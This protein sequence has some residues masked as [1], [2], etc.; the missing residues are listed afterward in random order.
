MARNNKSVTVFQTDYDFRSRVNEKLKSIENKE[1]EQMNSQE[2]LDY[3]SMLVQGTNYIEKSN[4]IIKNT[5]TKWEK[6]TAKGT[7]GEVNKVLNQLKE[8]DF[9]SMISGKKQDAEEMLDKTLKFNEI[10]NMIH[11][12]QKGGTT[13]ESLYS[14]KQAYDY[15]QG[16][17]NSKE[18]TSLFGFDLE[19]TGGTNTQGIWTPDS[20]TEYSMQEIDLKTKNRLRNDTILIGITEKEGEALKKE[21]GQAIKDGTISTN[22]RLRVSASRY[23][24]YGDDTVKQTISKTAEGYYKVGEFI[25]PDLSEYQNIKKIFAGIDKFVEI[26]KEMEREA[27]LHGGIRADH[28]AVGE[29]IKYSMDKINSNKAALVGYNHIGH[30]IPIMQNQLLRWKNLYK[31]NKNVNQELVNKIFDL[32]MDMEAKRTMD[33][34]GGVRAF[35]EYNGANKLYPGSNMENVKKIS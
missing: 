20:I 27:H 33:L 2:M 8:Y 19:T 32:D 18:Q 5:A 9:Y 3:L 21:I 6:K 12:E 26:G 25:D 22:E 23:S 24:L 17:R 34:F 29:S 15:I 4:N 7:Y 10:N 11:S 16:L 31:D 35:L 14:F 28:K 1:I 13:N 30:D